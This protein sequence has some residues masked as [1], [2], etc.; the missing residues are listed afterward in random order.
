MIQPP[1]TCG[2]WSVSQSDDVSFL[3]WIDGY[4]L[5]ASSLYREK[6]CD[7]EGEMFHVKHSSSL[8]IIRDGS[9]EERYSI[10]LLF[11]KFFPLILQGVY[12]SLVGKHDQISNTDAPLCDAFVM[13]KLIRSPRF[14]RLAKARTNRIWWQETPGKCL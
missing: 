10:S 13:E 6:A 12:R 5:I 8:L 14:F 2:K 11:E 9:L 1:L 3:F 4:S 7:C